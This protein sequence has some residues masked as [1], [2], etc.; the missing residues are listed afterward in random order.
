MDGWMGSW[1]W[2]GCWHMISC[3]SMLVRWKVAGVVERYEWKAWSGTD[4]ISNITTV[5]YWVFVWVVDGL[6]VGERENRWL[7]LVRVIRLGVLIQDVR[8]CT[9]Q[10]T[11]HYGKRIWRGITYRMKFA[12]DNNIKPHQHAYSHTHEY[13]SLRKLCF[14]ENTICRT[15]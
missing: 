15:C 7:G 14:H 9:E 4:M 11:L 2:I 13:L 3:I 12:I 1:G 6:D 8:H 5:L 10:C